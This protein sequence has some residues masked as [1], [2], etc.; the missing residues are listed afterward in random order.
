MKTASLVSTAAL[1][2]GGSLLF[3]SP[4]FAEEIVPVETQ[5][6]VEE[7]VC[8]E[9]DSTK[10]DLKAGNTTFEIIADEGYL[11]TGYCVKAGSALQGDGPEYVEVDPPQESVIIE[12]STGKD[13]SHYSFS[14][15]LAPTT[16]P[17]TPPATTPPATTPPASTTPPAGGGDGAAALAETGFE[18]GWLAFIGIGALALGG[19]LIAPRLM[20]KRR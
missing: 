5:A 14:Q 17:T 7:K 4:A 16:P 19:A 3:A 20:A 2:L 1:V 9:L 12:H 15:E 6:P 18:N 11:I 13:I 8:D 10:I